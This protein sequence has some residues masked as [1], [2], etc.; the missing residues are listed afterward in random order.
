MYEVQYGDKTGYV[1]KTYVGSFA[2][3]GWYTGDFNGGMPAMLHKKELVLN[4]QQTQNMLKTVEF[5]DRMVSPLRVL[6]SKMQSVKST[7]GSPNIQIGSIN[8]DFS[9]NEIKNGKDAAKEMMKEMTNLIGTQF[10]K[11]L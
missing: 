7:G 3:G 5:T 9:N 4:Q 2:S 11:R 6:V 1:N 10:N 8:N